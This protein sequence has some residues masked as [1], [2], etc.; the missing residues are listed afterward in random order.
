[1]KRVYISQYSDKSLIEYLSA[2]GYL[3]Q[4][5]PPG[6]RTYAAVDAHPDLYLC[7]MGV[8]RHARIFQGDPQEL[9]AA[10]PDNIRFN[11]VCLDNYLIHHIK[12]TSPALLREAQETGLALIHVRQG[13][14]KCSCVVVDGHSLITFDEGICRTL[15]SY[16]DIDVLKIRPGFVRLNGLAYGS[17]PT[18]ILRQYVS[19]S[20]IAGCAFNTF[21]II[22]SPTSA[23]FLPTSDHHAAFSYSCARKRRKDGRSANAGSGSVSES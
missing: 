17:P 7:K 3:P 23:V 4:L 16:P 18:R 10:Y 15:R 11:A 19:L 21:R 1:M 5:I 12:H 13:Y 22:R 20:R 8:T 2:S 9:G 14:T 6:G